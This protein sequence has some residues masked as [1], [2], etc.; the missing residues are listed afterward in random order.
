VPCSGCCVC[1]GRPAG[2]QPCCRESTQAAC[3]VSKPTCC[4]AHPA[5]RSC[6][7]IR[8]LYETI[9]GPRRC[10]EREREK[11]V[12][13]LARAEVALQAARSSKQQTG[14]QVRGGGGGG[15]GA[16]EHCKGNSGWV[17]ASFLPHAC[18]TVAAPTWQLASPGSTFT[19]P[20]LCLCLCL[21][22]PALACSWGSS[23]RT[24]GQR[25][26][27]WRRRGTAPHRLPRNSGPPT[28]R[29][30]AR[31]APA[32]VHKRERRQHQPWT[33]RC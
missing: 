17:V 28:V 20:S 30:R 6:R 25:W 13:A 22:L 11:L 19:S 21:C 16:L 4:P 32:S 10:S 18:M 12:V 9:Q 33:N 2:R 7:D 1:A 15:G 29:R 8:L 24:C 5:W 23:G 14:Q 27:S 31:M 3:R 26:H